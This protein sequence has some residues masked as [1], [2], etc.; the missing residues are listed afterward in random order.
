MANDPETPLEWKARILME[1]ASYAYP[2]P[3]G[4]R[5]ESEGSSP[6]QVTVVYASTKSVVAEA[7]KVSCH[8]ERIWESPGLLR[9]SSVR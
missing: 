5:N 9:L 7:P 8:Q 4:E 3:R 1:L 2:K 6:L